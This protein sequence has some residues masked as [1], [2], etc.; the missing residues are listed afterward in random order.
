MLTLQSAWHHAAL[1]RDA[2]VR[3]GRVDAVKAR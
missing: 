1:R 2:M 3:A